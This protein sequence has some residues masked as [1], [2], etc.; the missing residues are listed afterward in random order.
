MLLEVVQQLVILFDADGLDMPIYTS[1]L[2]HPYPI[3]CIT[4]RSSVELPSW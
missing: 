1:L 2:L 4:F 3:I